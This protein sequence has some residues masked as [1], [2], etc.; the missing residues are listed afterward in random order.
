M[1]RFTGALAGSQSQNRTA[2]VEQFAF[3]TPSALTI[4]ND[5]R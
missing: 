2:S 3:G 1:G 4:R 5:T